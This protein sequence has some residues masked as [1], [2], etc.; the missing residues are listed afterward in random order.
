MEL[1]FHLVPA[2]KQPQNLYDIHLVLYVQSQTPD[3][4]L[5]YRPKHVVC[6]SLLYRA[7]CFNLLFIVPIHAL[8]CTLKH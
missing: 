3:D 5:R 2:S 1:Q 8:H 7:C 6:S 4:G